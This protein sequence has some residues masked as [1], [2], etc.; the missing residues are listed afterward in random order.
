M[1]TSALV[2]RLEAVRSLRNS[3][4]RKTHTPTKQ[5][6]T[7][8]LERVARKMGGGG[9]DESGAPP[10]IA[11]YQSMINK[12][13]VTAIAAIEKLGCQ[14]PVGDIMRKGFNNIME[15]LKR[16]PNAKKPDQVS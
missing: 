1:A 7:S 13:L 9:G 2:D 11:D 6:V 14:E 15:L 16:L 12:E 4:K 5:Q 10:Y 3:R 8:R